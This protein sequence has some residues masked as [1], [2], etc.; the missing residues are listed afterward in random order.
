M[1]IVITGATRGLGLAAARAL[2]ASGHTVVICSEDGDDVARTLNALE[3]EGLHARGT[4]CDISSEQEVLKLGRFAREDGQ[5]VDAWVNNAGLPGITG[6][7]DEVPTAYLQRLIDTNIKGT[8]LCSVHA[9]RMFHAQGHGRLLNVLGRGAK[10][11]VPFSNAYGPAKTWIRS[12]TRALA[13]EVRG[14]NIAVAT[15]QPGLVHTKMTLDVQVVAGHE[16]RMKLLPAAQRYLGNEPEFAG[17]YLARIVTG[18]M[19][20]GKAYRLPVFGP[21]VRRLLA[22][23]PDVAITTRT[24]KPE[25]DSP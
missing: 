15:F 17:E 8:C 13:S 20:N 2:L 9:L 1:N 19:R 18:R 7:T 16:H 25:N 23:A 22:G 24:I 11:P 14:T 3:R 6:R 4:R 12:F 21:A 10:T 5:S